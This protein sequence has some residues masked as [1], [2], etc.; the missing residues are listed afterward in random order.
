MIK[1]D[2]IGRVHLSWELKRM[3]KETIDGVEYVAV[4]NVQRLFNTIANK[5][6]DWH[7]SA[8]RGTEGER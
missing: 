6:N 4:E 1:C 5:P 8:E 3:P 2:D 7:K